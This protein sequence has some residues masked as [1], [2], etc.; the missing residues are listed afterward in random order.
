[1]AG[2]SGVYEVTDDGA[3]LY[4]RVSPGA[5]LN[6]V[7]GLWTGADGERRLALKVTAPP[8]KGKANAAV[9]VLLAGALGLPKSALTVASG[10]TSRLKTI[11]VRGDRAAL[12][13]ALGALA[14][15]LS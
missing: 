11:V 3:Q 7:Y 6:E 5:K 13:S 10:D 2:R 4:V 9:L 14:G 1:M 15:E 8:D 12:A